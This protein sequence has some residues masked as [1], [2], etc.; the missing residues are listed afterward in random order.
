ML[1]ISV[2]QYNYVLD[3]I[4][5][6][7]TLLVTSTGQFLFRG[8]YFI[9]NME[10]YSNKAGYFKFKLILNPHSLTDIAVITSF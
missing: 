1:F 5:K 9:A 6:S 3:S 8:Y 4:I 10:C 7:K 2:I